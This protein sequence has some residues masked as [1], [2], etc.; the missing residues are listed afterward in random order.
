M[1][2]VALIVKALENSSNKGDVVLDPFGGSGSTLIACEQ[3]NR[4]ARLIE[5]EPRYV[6]VIC[7]RWQEHT[8]RTPLREGRPVSFIS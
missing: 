7:R 4:R 8:G 6:D 5:L 3:T 1:K 2:P